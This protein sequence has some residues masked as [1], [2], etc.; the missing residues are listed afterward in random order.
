MPRECHL[1]QNSREMPF[2]EH[3]ACH[4]LINRGSSL[5]MPLE[6]SSINRGQMSSKFR[7]ADWLTVKCLS[8]SF[9]GTHASPR[10]TR[11]FVHFLVSCTVCSRWSKEY[12]KHVHSLHLSFAIAEGCANYCQL[13][14]CFIFVWADKWLS[15]HNCAMQMASSFSS[16][17]F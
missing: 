17:K 8:H 11:V 15:T 16:R 1:R 5:A 10:G 4:L 2:V 7:K 9:R 6:P 3:L 13:G 14:L 12:M